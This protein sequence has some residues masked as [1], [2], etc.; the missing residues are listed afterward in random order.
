MLELGGAS[1]SAHEE[2]GRLAG[3]KVARLYL[4]GER[5]GNVAEGAL[6]EGLA[7]SAIIVANSHKEILEDLLGIV[8][9]GDCILVKG[10]RGM[11][12]DVVAEGLRNSLRPAKPKGAGA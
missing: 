7:H 12:M 6:A 4:A 1:A 11:R 2:V 5:A 9:E 10:S 8:R 3:R